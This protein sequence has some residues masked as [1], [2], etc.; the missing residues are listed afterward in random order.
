MAG[1]NKK[2]K[3]EFVTTSESL[4]AEISANPES[5]RVKEFAQI[6]EPI[7]R[8]FVRM[9]KSNFTCIPD[10]DQDDIVQ[11][12]FVSVL[13]AMAKFQYD[14][15]RGS[16]RGY[17]ARV[18]RNHVIAYQKSKAANAMPSLDGD[19]NG[20]IERKASECRDAI[21]GMR[22]DHEL[23]L[24][25]WS[26][27][28][29]SVLANNNFAPNSKAIFRRYVLDEFPVEKVAEE[30]KIKP[31]AVYQIKNRILKAVRA[32]LDE[33]RRKTSGNDL[34]SLLETLTEESRE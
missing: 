31:N 12:A 15:R 24:K 4:I 9:S 16:F 13:K 14:K 20:T 5:P 17:L 1:E 6:Y 21:D 3:N 34:E 28:L 2:G 29:S 8:R 25:I 19:E 30:F 11:E 32:K 23:M 22:R 27:A 33:A 7:L 18:V 10:C 26:A